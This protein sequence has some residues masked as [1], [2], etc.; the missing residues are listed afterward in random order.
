MNRNK[1]IRKAIRS[2]SGFLTDLEIALFLNETFAGISV[3][4]QEIKIQ[5]N[6]ILIGKFSKVEKDFAAFGKEVNDDSK[7]K[8]FNQR[9]DNR[10]N[11]Y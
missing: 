6:L 4:V 2:F 8:W 1:I 7:S 11:C 10:G 5:R 9:Y 3:V